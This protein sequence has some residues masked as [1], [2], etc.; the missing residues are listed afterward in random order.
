MK[1]DQIPSIMQA[2]GFYP[3][4]QDIEDMRNEVVYGKFGAIQTDITDDIGFEELIKRN[5]SNN[6]S[7]FKPSP[8]FPNYEQGK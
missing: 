5:S 2:M 7:V 1:L 4:K 3:S 8:C 6:F